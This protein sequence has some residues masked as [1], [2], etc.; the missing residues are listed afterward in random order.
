M[1]VIIEESVKTIN[2]DVA[3]QTQK[4]TVN[5]EY[6]GCMK[7]IQFYPRENVPEEAK[8]IMYGVNFYTQKYSFCSPQC[9]SKYM[10]SYK[11]SDP[12]AQPVRKMDTPQ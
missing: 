3:E 7:S 5:C 2:G 10:E 8:N 11:P 6:L 12:N 9:L 4:V 1:P